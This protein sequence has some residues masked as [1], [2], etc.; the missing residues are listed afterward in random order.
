[1]ITVLVVLLEV[2][3]IHNVQNTT[4]W[5]YSRSNSFM[6]SVYHET[7]SCTSVAFNDSDNRFN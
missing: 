5:L 2:S 3:V 6:L 4:V 7:S 1:M